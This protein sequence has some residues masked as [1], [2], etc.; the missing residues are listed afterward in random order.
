MPACLFLLGMRNTFL[1]GK[2][3][4]GTTSQGF[5]V[6]L[7]LS[8]LKIFHWQWNFFC[9][10]DRSKLVWTRFPLFL[11]LSG[12]RVC[13]LVYM[14]WRNSRFSSQGFFW[15]NHS[16]WDG[17]F[18]LLLLMLGTMWHSAPH[19]LFSYKHIFIPLTLPI[20]ILASEIEALSPLRGRMLSH[21]VIC[22][23][24]LFGSYLCFA[25]LFND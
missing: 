2:F 15:R 25:Q 6:W 3:P 5:W 21:R 9:K 24:S 4:K 10:C 8:V 23:V 17:Y 16:F 12:A 1:D 19:F 11:L 18:C 13:L 7:Q 22:F 14:H 20:E